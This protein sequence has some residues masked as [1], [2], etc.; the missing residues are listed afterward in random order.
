MKMQQHSDRKARVRTFIQ[1]SGLLHKSGIMGAFS[2]APGDDLQAHENF[3]KA[4]QL[5][6]FLTMCFEK[7][8]FDEDDLEKWKLV[9]KKLF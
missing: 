9:G 6:G 8:T 1:A 5:L 7:N 2:I 4:A 3:E